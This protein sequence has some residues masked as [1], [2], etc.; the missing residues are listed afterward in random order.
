VAESASGNVLEF[1]V[2]VVGG[3]FNFLVLLILSFYLSMNE[4]AIENF[5]RIVTPKE[6][7]ERLV[8]LWKRTQYKIG[9]WFQGQLLLGLIVGVLIYISLLFI[10]VKYSLLLALL[11]A[12]MEL[13]PFGIIFAAVPAVALGFVGQGSTGALMV[14]GV[15]LIVHELEL[16]VI[17][18]LVTE[19]MI[20]VSSFVVVLS[21]LVGLELAGFW[22][23]VLGVPFAVLLTEIIDEVKER[24]GLM[25]TKA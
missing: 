6:Q 17:S 20:G 7:T 24:K 13:V 12:L 2:S 10:G 8:G 1:A 25:D 19:K 23:M 22:G 16:N 21:I 11:A 5:L 14:A 3:M 18:P 15:Y 4:R 9:L